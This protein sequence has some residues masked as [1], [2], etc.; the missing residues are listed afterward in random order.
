MTDQLIGHVLSVCN[1]AWRTLSSQ[2]SDSNGFCH[3]CVTLVHSQ[4]V[5]R[6]FH[7][8]VYD[9]AW[10]WLM[11]SSHFLTRS[12]VLAA[13]TTTEY[14]HVNGTVVRSVTFERTPSSALK[15]DNS[16]AGHKSHLDLWPVADMC[17]KTVF[18][19][20]ISKSL[21]WGQTPGYLFV[22]AG[23]QLSKPCIKA[24]IKMLL[25]DCSS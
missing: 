21:T 17:V 20:Y 7:G 19:L 11:T 25:L 6:L 15:T 14:F 1:A 18:D 16:A 5:F 24:V 12:F 10:S 4:I 23:I 22:P 13:G 8:Q 2:S 9:G 3:L